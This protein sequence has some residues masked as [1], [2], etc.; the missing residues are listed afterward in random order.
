MR[1]IVQ[2]EEGV[3][4]AACWQNPWDIDKWVTGGERDAVLEVTT[5]RGDVGD[6]EDGRE[7]EKTRA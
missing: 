4:V 1:Q 2:L 3:V 5:R 7:Q 6:E